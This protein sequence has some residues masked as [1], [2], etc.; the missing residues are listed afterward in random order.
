M[1]IVGSIVGCNSSD[2]DDKDKRNEHWAWWVDAKTGKGKWIPVADEMT[3]KNGRIILFYFN[4]NVY[5]KGKVKDGKYVDT[6]FKYDYQGKLY[7][8]HLWK[9]DSIYYLN[10]GLIKNFR[11]DG[12][13]SSEGIVTNHTAGNK[14]VAYYK[15]G[16][17]KWERDY[18][19]GDTGSLVTY[20]ENGQIRDSA[21]HLNDLSWGVKDVYEVKIWYENG[22]VAQIRLWKNKLLNGQELNFYSNGQIKDSCYYVDGKSKGLFKEWYE[23]GVLK[24][25]VDLKNSHANGV[26]KYYYESGKIKTVGFARN[27]Q[28]NDGTDYDEKGN[29]IRTVK[30]GVVQK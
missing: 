9:N 7:G 20:F 5:E 8:Y 18:T 13:K 21:I 24:A 4:G 3:L 14:W 30:D 25:C 15:N 6:T 11:S 23:N 26:V 1:V 22:A 19:R 10:D 29:I 17:K 27:D 16:N 2:I 12:T 28:L